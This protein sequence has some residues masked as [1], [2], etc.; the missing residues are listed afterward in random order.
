MKSSQKPSKR[1]AILNA[2]L[3]IVVERGFHDAPM[4]LVARR[5]GAS[6]GVI[7]HYF[8]SKE[9]IIEALYERIRTVKR[10]TILAG[11]TPEM[12]PKEAFLHVA[13]NIYHFYRSQSKELR[14]LEQYE[15]AGFPCEPQTAAPI[16][17][18]LAAFERRFANQ[19]NG[20]LLK[21]WP[22]AILQELTAG[23]AIRLARLSDEISPG[24]F[25]EIAESIW[26]ILKA[27][28]SAKT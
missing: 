25:E 15:H 20:G 18:E 8:A 26:E 1:E 5:S 27:Q 9:A 13:R 6:A 17:D 28:P 21:N 3:D 4:S 10:T 23:V 16:D 22:Q 14:F 7:Y 19:D 24:L 2:M 12:P 11:Y